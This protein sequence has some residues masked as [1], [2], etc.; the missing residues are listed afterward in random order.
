MLKNVER[1]KKSGGTIGVGTD[2][3]G[4]HLSFFGYYW[5]ELK[6][7][8]SAGFTNAGALKAATI[9]NAGIIGM[10]DSIGTIEPTK[11]ADFTIIDGDPL[12]DISMTKNIAM[13][14]KNGEIVVRNGNVVL[15]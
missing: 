1:I 11:Y 10:A 2:C 4:T 9:V 8:T 6:W 7:L 15:S 5:K 3:C 12:Q 14:V 13:V